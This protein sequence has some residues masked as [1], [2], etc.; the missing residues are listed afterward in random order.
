MDAATLKRI[1]ETLSKSEEL[2]RTAFLAS[3]DSVNLNLL[4]NGAYIDINEGFTRLTGYTREEVQGKTSLDIGIWSDPRDRERLVAALRRFGYVENFEAE[5]RRKNGEIGVGLMSARLLS[6][7]GHSVIL[8][9]TRDITERKL[10]ERL[11]AE[12]EEKYRALFNIS[13]LAI[14]IR[15]REGKI[16]LANPAAAR[17]LEASQPDDLVGKSYLTLV[18][19]KDRELSRIRIESAFRIAADP[20]AAGE[21]L[22]RH[23]APRRH[24]LVTLTG[25]AVPVESTGIAFKHGGE[26]FIQ[27]IFRDITDEL[28]A[29]LALRREEKRREITL[30]LNRMIDAPLEAIVQRAAEGCLTLSASRA[31]AIHLLAPEDGCAV[32][33]GVVAARTPSGDAASSVAPAPPS[34]KDGLWREPLRQGRA[35]IFEASGAEP[36]PV[37]D[38]LP[39]SEPARRFLGIPVFERGRGVLVGCFVDKAEPYDERDIGLL[40][41]ALTDLGGIIQRKQAE[42]ALRESERRFRTAFENASVGITLVDLDGTYLEVNRAMAAMLGYEPQDLVGRKVV[43]FIHPEDLG[44]RD[45]FVRALIEG[46]L[47]SG[48]QERRFIHRDGSIVWV[49][50]W[51]TLQKDGRGNPLYFISLVQDITARKK[52][53]EEK[54]RLESQLLQAQKME[55]IGALAG[56]IAHDFNNILSAII[57]FTELA[58][59][60][61]GKAEEYLRESLKA[62]KR[63]KDLVRQILSFSRQ[64]GEERAPVSVALVAREVVKFLRASVPATIEIRLRGE[65]TAATV[66]ASSVELHQILMNLCT[67]AVHAIGDG[68]GLIEIEIEPCEIGA[69]KRTEFPELDPGRYVRLVVRDNGH[70]IPAAILDRIFDPYFTTKEKGVGTGLGLAVVHGIVKKA[71]GT[72]RVASEPGRGTQFEILLPQIDFTRPQEEEAAVAP[73]LGGKGRILFVDDEAML[74]EL[75]GRILEKL[76]YEVVTRTSPLE[77]LELFKR[78]PLD[79][80]LVVSDQTM[81]GMTGDLLARELLKIRPG[82]PIILCTGYS[83]RIDERRAREKGIRALVMK[84]ILVHE[85]D[86]AVRSALDG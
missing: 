25:R 30:A 49:N 16:T 3:P 62:A 68:A 59:L 66:L 46:R 6:I 65:K 48:E 17:L 72:V 39:G 36:Y 52:E 75:G 21:E 42:D 77:A 5:F 84:P 27:G 76:G 74:A 33:L 35:L 80:D 20:A 61:E 56:G 45:E 81:P 73:L 12:A 26:L 85:I 47:S 10:T 28:Q 55:A 34:G 64:G 18:H 60:A 54:S 19:P 67:N 11:L 1:Q 40:Q 78:R 2:F 24:R 53:A 43:D 32:T 70:G 63:A 38:F 83:Q 82:L 13:S 86:A 22:L 37:E 31:G 15:N 69:A 71:N 7:A 4:E 44:R 51:A 50:I 14:L 58:M 9:I 29:E 57:G 23:L 41:V 8:S 79:F